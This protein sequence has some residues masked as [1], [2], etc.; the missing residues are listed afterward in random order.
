MPAYFL[1]ASALTKRFVHEPGTPY[2]LTLR[3]Q[4]DSVAACTLSIVEVTSALARRVSAGDTSEEDL[5]AALAAMEADFRAF[6]VI[7]IGGAVIAQ[8]ADLA[9]AHAL[10]GADAIQLAAA[11]VFS[12]TSG[13]AAQVGF[14][15]SDRELNTAAA[16]EGFNVIDPRER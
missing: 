5:A 7:E 12:G 9:R 2:V 6:Q 4:T 13:G 14:V 3:P 16:A 8:A 15:S 11:I 10:R 1:D